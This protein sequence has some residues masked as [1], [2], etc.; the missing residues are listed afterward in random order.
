MSGHCDHKKM[1]FC[2]KPYKTE[3][4]K[5]KENVSLSRFKTWTLMLCAPLKVSLVYFSIFTLLRILKN[6]F[7]KNKVPY[8]TLCF[9]SYDPDLH[10]FFEVLFCGCLA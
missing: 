8:Q 5:Q 10:L 1:I 4:M 9:T 6:P 7:Y 2:L 3:K